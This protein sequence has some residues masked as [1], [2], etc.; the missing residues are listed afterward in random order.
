LGLPLRLPSWAEPQSAPYLAAAPRDLGAKIGVAWR[1]NALPDP[2]RSM[3]PDDAAKLLSLPGA[4]SPQPEDTGAKNFTET[5]RIIAGLDLVISVDTSIAYLAGAMGKPA[6]VLL[7]AGSRDWRWRRENPFYPTARLF[8]QS[9]AGDWDAVI[10][11]VPNL[12]DSG[13]ATG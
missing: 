1:G 11:E 3:A 4:T 9:V 2:A 12:V 10:G 13:P 7:H 5:A 8:K 6:W